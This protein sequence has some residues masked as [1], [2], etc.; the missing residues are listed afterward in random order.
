MKNCD[1]I[2]QEYIAQI[3]TQGEI[4]LVFIAG[5]FSHS[6]LKKPAPKDFRVQLQ[7]GG[8]WIPTVPSATVLAQ[9]QAIVNSIQEPLLYARVDGVEISDDLVIN[10]L[11][12]IEPSLYFKFNKESQDRFAESVSR[13]WD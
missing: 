13:L 2:L 7:F 3:V 5:Q 11:E 12:L 1:I 6:I 4:S 8:T 9:A 10:E